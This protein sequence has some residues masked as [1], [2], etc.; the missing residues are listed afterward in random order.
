MRAKDARQ[1]IDSSTLSEGCKEL[2]VGIIDA[3][4]SDRELTSEEETEINGLLDIEVKMTNAEVELL[5]SQI[6]ELRIM[7]D[8]IDEALEQAS[9]ELD[10]FVE[11]LQLEL[12]APSSKDS[13]EKKSKEL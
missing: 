11:Q 12:G 5:D 3:G 2:I 1:Y 6:D 4:D 10:S 8:T 7:K 9:G 13:A